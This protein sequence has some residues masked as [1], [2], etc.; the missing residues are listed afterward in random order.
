MADVA[1]D[2]TPGEFAESLFAGV[3][4][5]LDELSGSSA[6]LLRWLAQYGLGEAAAPADVVRAVAETLRKTAGGVPVTVAVEVPRCPAHGRAAC[7]R[8]S[9][10]P[11]GCDEHGPA[12]GCDYYSTTGMHWDTCPNRVR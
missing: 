11:A 12:K 9:L 6:T 5:T 7:D 8:C 1:V 10:N 3:A 4:E 2:L